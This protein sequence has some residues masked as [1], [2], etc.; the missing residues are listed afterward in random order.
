[1]FTFKR[2]A[3]ASLAVVALTIGASLSSAPSAMAI[4]SGCHYQMSNRDAIGTC[5]NG[6][7]EFRIVL[8]CSKSPDRTTLWAKPGQYVSVHCLV[9]MPYGVSFQTH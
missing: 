1:M 4:P 7:G 6:T 5:D 9:G 8:D 3:T 2:K